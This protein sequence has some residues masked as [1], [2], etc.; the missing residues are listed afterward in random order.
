LV[1]R[2]VNLAGEGDGGLYGDLGAMLREWSSVGYGFV[3]YFGLQRF[4]NAHAPTHSIG[5]ALLKHNWEEVRCFAVI[6]GGP[7]LGAGTTSLSSL[8]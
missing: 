8:S 4:G 3:N 7:N 6:D 1:I 5:K 2:N